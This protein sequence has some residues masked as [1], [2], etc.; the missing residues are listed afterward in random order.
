MSVVTHFCSQKFNEPLGTQ[1]F[2]NALVKAF[3]FSAENFK[4]ILF[5]CAIKAENWLLAF[6]YVRWLHT[7]VI[8]S[9]VS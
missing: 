6:E 1:H 8:V 4:S 3:L 7:S 5:Y 9:A 2:D